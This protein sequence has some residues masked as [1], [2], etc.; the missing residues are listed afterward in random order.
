MAKKKTPISI[1][2]LAQMAELSTATISRVL[3]NTG[4][5]SEATRDRVMSLVRRTGYSPNVAAKALRTKTARAV[6]L[7]IPDIANEFFS[8]IVNSVERFFFENSYSIFVC[9]TGEDARRNETMLTSL[10]GKGVDGLIYISR[11]E[12]DFETLGLP[13]VCLDRLPRRD[14]GVATVGSDNY[15]G[16]CLAARALIEAGSTRLVVLCDHEDYARHLSTVQNRIAGF[17]DTLAGLGVKWS[18]K[19]ILFSPVSALEAR[20][21]V[22]KAV[23]DGKRFDGLFASSDLPAIGA[24]AGLKDAGLRVPGDVNL[25]GYDD[26]SFCQYCDPPLTTI[27]QDTI[28]LGLEAGRLLLAIMEN[29]QPTQTH[30]QLPVKLILRASTRPPK[31]G[32]V[33]N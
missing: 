8:H 19:D 29:Q 33:E 10:R 11:Y 32:S 9:N 7:V 17:A 21:R 6:G 5:F 25:I 18:E 3:N 16:G 31:A 28:C 22:Y 24:L 20:K 23:R 26:I 2:H 14:E 1:K 30:L 13:V 12:L 27:R 4:R 15:S